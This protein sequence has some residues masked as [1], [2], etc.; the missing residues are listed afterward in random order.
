MFA[1]PS[2]LSFAP[3][4]FNDGPPAGND[5]MDIDDA[6]Y[7][8]PPA[9]SASPGFTDR[10]P[11]PSFAPAAAPN[12]T[13]GEDAYMRRLRMSGMAP[14][15]E[16]AQSSVTRSSPTPPTARSVSA[17]P[18]GSISKPSIDM[19]AKKAEAQARLAAVK[20][21]IEANAKGGNRTGPS[22]TPASS[23]SDTPPVTEATSSSTI[24]K[25]PV[26]YNLADTEVDA[27]LDREEKIS[28]SDSTMASQSP[29]P[30]QERS[31][32]PGQSGFGARMMAKMG[33][34]KGQGLGAK[35][36]GI[37]T[38]LVA[39]PTKRKKRS[40]QD[41]G[42]WA[43]PRNM[44]NIV[45]GKKRKVQST[46]DDEGEFGT[47]SSVIKLQGMLDEL[48]VAYEIEE[49][50][51]LQEIGEQFSENYGAIERLYIW[52]DQ[53]GGNNEVFVKFTNQ[54]SALKAVNG[55]DAM[56]FAGNPVRARFFDAEKFE[57]GQYA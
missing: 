54:L 44:G 40:D 8:A 3:P 34:E 45:G 30:N 47:I 11:P 25:A 39:Q 17:S 50:N 29:A 55:T 24:S 57:A 13:T 19:A 38:A 1:P 2:G 22:P 52:R 53:N 14:Q 12:D 35:G 7:H 36:E 46:D 42:G 27:V 10:V 33:W 21:K 41:G 31:R 9:S 32:L 37:T 56:T 5:P 51:L 43:A 20:A 4:S 23:L 26:R 49:N 15:P 18:V 6:E 28:K 16:R 48:D